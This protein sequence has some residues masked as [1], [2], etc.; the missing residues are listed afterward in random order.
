MRTATLAVIVVLL[1]LVVGA[2]QEQR[3]APDRATYKFATTTNLVIVNVTVR[4]KSGRPV[5]GLKAGDFTVVEDDKAQKLSVFEFQHLAADQPALPPV[6][7]T[8]ER[9][10]PALKTE[11]PKAAEAAP[12]P[13]NQISTSANGEVRYKDR[14]LI[15]L[16]FDFSSMPPDDQMRAQK[17]GEKFLK[18]QMT[19]ADLVSIMAF[20]NSLQILQDFT[21]DR[22]RLNEVMR[23]FHIG[24]GSELAMEASNGDDTS[25]EDTGAAF[26]ADDTEFNIF[27]TDRKLG[28]LETA[29]KM[30]RSLPEKKAIVYFSSGVG[31]TGVE[32][33]AQL[34]ATVNAAVRSNISFYPIDARGLV[35]SAPLGNASSASQRGTG[36]Y[37]GSAQQ[38]LR[39]RFNDQQETLST[40]ATDTGGRALLDNNDLAMGITQAQKDI[41]S[42]YILGYYSTNAQLDGKFRRIKVRLNNSQ[43]SAKLDYR[44]G[45]F[46]SKEFKNFSTADKEQQLAEAIALGDPMTD[47]DVALEVNYFRLARDRYFVPVA[48]KIPGSEVDL[49][50]KGGSQQAEF[51]F[52]G[53][54]RDTKGKIAATVRD[55]ITVKLTGDNA[56]QIGKR[57]LQYD[58]AFTLMPG[59]YTLKFLTRENTSGK[60]GTFETKFTIP[61][62][63]GV[64]DSSL[65]LSSVVWANQRVPL[66]SAVGAAERD[67]KLLASHPLVQEGQKLIPSITRVFRKSQDLYVYT[68]VYDPASEQGGK[69]TNLAATLSFFRGKV[70]AFESQP[71]VVN[72]ELPARRNTAAVQM[73]IP[74]A[75]LAPGR[76]T[77]QLNVIDEQGQKF[78]FRRTPMVLL[79]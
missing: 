63:Y 23:S 50:R 58:T 49:V 60:M 53:Q 15:V 76:Y 65:R 16:F 62:L 26:T 67:K 25:G 55:G 48:V 75:S 34:K 72:Q 64:Q 46:A 77:C 33:Q 39:D 1:G 24:E 27:N 40:L 73:Q 9:A 6:E 61:D 3:Q 56:E 68:E 57:Q 78:A 70:K 38:G 13:R 44:S 10:A 19:P 42:Y 37:T 18:E 2:Q 74:L 36:A 32:N 4:D 17:A 35:A 69:T 29:A 47:L 31:K 5:E 54:V 66:S 8:A 45:Y 51:D 7:K 30:L 14:R 79:P 43:L 20:G 59:D 21:D 22:D 28:A 71:I 11:R 12:A 52:I 41:N